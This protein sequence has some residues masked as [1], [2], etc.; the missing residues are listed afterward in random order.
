MTPAQRAHKNQYRLNYMKNNPE[1]HREYQRS[2]YAKHREERR[3]KQNE[4]YKKYRE[5]NNAR[6]AKR[7]AAKLSSTLGNFDN[8][9]KK[10]YKNCPKGHHVD[11]IVPL[12]GKNVSGLH[13]PWNLQY[14]PAIDNLKK[15]NKF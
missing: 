14:L 13:V 12:Q 7:R 10:I 9:I 15:S 2:D 4:R 3:K 1:K 8:E 5:T 11:H 6:A